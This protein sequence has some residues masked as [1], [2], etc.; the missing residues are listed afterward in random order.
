[1]Y[2]T[3]THDDPS[4]PNSPLTTN[5][6][7]SAPP[8]TLR[9]DFQIQYLA[10]EVSEYTPE[11]SNPTIEPS[12]QQNNTRR[13]RR[14]SSAEDSLTRQELQRFQEIRDFGG[15]A[16]SSSQ[17]FHNQSGKAAP[18]RPRLMTKNMRRDIDDSLVQ[19]GN[20]YSN[21][22]LQKRSSNTSTN[23]YTHLNG[24]SNTQS[25]GYGAESSKP[26]STFFGHDREEVARLLIQGLNDLGY[27]DSANA[28]RRESGYELESPTV[29]AF[30]DSV[31]NGEWSEAESLLFGSTARNEGGVR[32]NHGH[33]SHYDGFPLAEGTDKD[34]L[35]FQLR[36][37]KYLE[38]LEERDHAGALM[39]LRHELTPL[40]RDVSQLH[41]LSGLMVCPTPEDLRLQAAWDG[42]HGT[43]RHTL[44]SEL[45]DSISPSVMIPE[46]RLA[47]LLNQVK[48]NQ[49]S[50]CHY[51]NP[52]TQMSLFTDHVCDKDQFPLQTIHELSQREEVWYLKFSH[53][54]TRL[55]T[56]GQD[57]RV[58][59]YETHTFKEAY[60]L[61]EH[62]RFVAFLAWSPDDSKLVTC[63]DDR[64]AKVWD[65]A[66]GHCL[67]TIDNHDEPLTAA[68]WTPD[69]RHFI[70]G[71][72]DKKSSLF[73]WTDK[74][75]KVYSWTN[76]YR[77]NAL[78]ISPDGQRLVTLSDE[79]QIH[80]YNLQTREEEY[81]MRLK[82]LLTCVTISRD[83]K[84][85][86]VN[87]ANNEL[88]LID[89]NSAEI[90]QRFLGQKQNDFYIRSTFGGADENLVISGSEGRVYLQPQ[91][92]LTVYR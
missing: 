7:I 39:V 13:R 25:N 43:S 27:V 44:L 40:H 59:I 21:G 62:T 16:E 1:L 14:S 92:I 3:S 41:I 35:R 82:S 38:L 49:I 60:T 63:S 55:A 53:D 56:C 74:A 19:N 91:N 33:L 87:M 26:S 77:V 79:P 73:L 75:E 15:Q 84:Y 51:H 12:I 36:K 88:Q 5:T 34:D 52:T 22:S 57:S 64:T 2:T 90:V 10:Q 31:L 58:V 28:L 76:N 42:A 17:I 32:L 69:G 48:Q 24:H 20:R 72:L 11:A 46:H 78:A 85:M 47:T 65:T 37:Q 6:I 67:Y 45:S 54:G 86:L 18:K 68:A 66:T 9:D 4:T 81:S 83:S 23:G 8:Q 30:R 50:K 80:V 61:T 71:S 70:T 29:A 89:I